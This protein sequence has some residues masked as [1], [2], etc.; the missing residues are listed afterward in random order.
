LVEFRFRNPC[1][2][3][4]LIFEGWYVGLRFTGASLALNDWG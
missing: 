1:A 4:R 3:F 2:R